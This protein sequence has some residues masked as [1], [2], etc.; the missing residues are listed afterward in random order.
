MRLDLASGS[1]PHGPAA[2]AAGALLRH[3]LAALPEEHPAAY[4][5][6]VAL[7]FVVVNLVAS[8]FLAAAW[9]E[10]WLDTVVAGD[11][12]RLVL[13]ITATFLAGMVECSRRLL[14]V[15]TDL[16][17]VASEGRPGG[18]EVGVYL[19]QVTGRDPQ[20]RAIAAANLKL[21]LSA[22]I[23]T[24]RHVAASLVVLGLIGTV[25]GFIIALSG[26]E[27]GA[28]ARVESVGPMVSTLVNGMSVALYTT[29]VGAVLNIWLTINYRLLEAATVRLLAAVMD[30]GERDARD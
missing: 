30:R 17:R 8:A 26:V 12:T 19:R 23:A 27:A 28:A 13:V 2:P 6:V 10:G 16:D 18:G 15:S 5:H 9:L 20:S 7:R 3:W 14:Q 1:S 4:R 25:I 11:Q 29:L 21:K 24:V 22:R